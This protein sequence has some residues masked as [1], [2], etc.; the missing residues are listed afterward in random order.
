MRIQHSFETPQAMAEAVAQRTAQ[1]L[2]DAIAQRGRAMLALSG[3][4]T[5]RLYLAVLADLFLDWNKLDVRLI[6][7]RW[8]A[9][10]HPDSNE[11][12][13][14]QMLPQAQVIGLFNGAAS[15]VAGCAAAVE[16]LESCPEPWDV[17]L[18]GLGGDGHIASLFPGTDAVDDPTPYCLPVMTAPQHP[19]M[20]LSAAALLRFHHPLMILSGVE[21]RQV[22]QD[23]EAKMLPARILARA[24]DRLETFWSA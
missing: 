22:W 9:L 24:G 14:R 11:G 6:D 3:G 20:S 5:P 7:E 19:R 13:I 1:L 23:A 16:S 4:S 2:N 12:M 21:K 15:P 10:D 18:L 8:V 17:A